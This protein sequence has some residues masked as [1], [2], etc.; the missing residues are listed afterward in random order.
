MSPALEAG[1]LVMVQG[2]PASGIQAEDIIVFND[3]DGT[4]TIHRVIRTETLQNGTIQ[5]KTKGDANPS[6]DAYWTL[7]QS[8]HGRVIYRIPY[9][10]WLALDPTVPIMILSIIA[11]IMIL[12]PEKRRKRRR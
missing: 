5:F 9:I 4:P 7:E 11:I 8:V 6:E 12:W 2:V 10:G 3:P 1:D